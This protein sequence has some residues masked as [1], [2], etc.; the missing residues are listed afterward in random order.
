MSE[1]FICDAVRTPLTSLRTNIEVLAGERTLP[2]QDRE[3]LLGDV[4]YWRGQAKVRDAL[5][6]LGGLNFAIF[7]TTF[8]IPVADHCEDPT[9]KGDG[10][11]HEGYHASRLGLKGIPGEWRLYA[12]V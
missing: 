9:L 2:P 12:A 8:G 3:R 11:A 5:G 6:A 10:C 1:A 7:Y 4:A